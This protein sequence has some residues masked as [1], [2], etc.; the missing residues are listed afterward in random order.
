MTESAERRE[1]EVSVM[2]RLSEAQQTAEH[3]HMEGKDAE[4]IRTLQDAI[5]L[6]EQAGGEDIKALMEKRLTQLGGKPL[7]PEEFARRKVSERI[8][9]VQKEL[10]RIQDIDYLQQ[11]EK[12]RPEAAGDHARRVA[13][14]KTEL[15]RLNEKKRKL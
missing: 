15:N 13:E 5:V 6:A 3:L 14:L 7:S 4:A 8:A 12:Q 9:E 1:E 10:I 11:L 2:Q